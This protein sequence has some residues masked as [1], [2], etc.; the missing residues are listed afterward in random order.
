MQNLAHTTV[1]IGTEQIRLRLDRIF[2][3]SVLGNLDD[4]TQSRGSLGRWMVTDMTRR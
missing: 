3:S 4:V 2:W 1:G